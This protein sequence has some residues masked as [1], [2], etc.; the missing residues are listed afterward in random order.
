MDFNYLVNLKGCPE[1]VGKDFFCSDNNLTSLEGNLKSL[2]L[3][4]YCDNTPLSSM[5]NDVGIDFIIGFN[6]FKVIQDG[7]VNLK[8][9]KYV[10]E[11]FDRPIYL[12][13]IKK[14]YTIK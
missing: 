2:G 1:R 12:K 8:R 14:Y 11:V 9:L 3:F 7:V 4:L 5:F 10:M 13:E 6:A